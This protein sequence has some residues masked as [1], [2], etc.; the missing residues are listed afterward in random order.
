LPSS[1]HWLRTAIFERLT[2]AAVQLEPIAGTLFAEQRRSG[3]T[4]ASRIT[5]EVDIHLIASTALLSL[6]LLQ[7]LMPSATQKRS[8]KGRCRRRGRRARSSSQLS[9][10]GR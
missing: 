3:V 6:R 9:K 2:V 5:L 4:G 10:S 1:N 7:Q 8:H